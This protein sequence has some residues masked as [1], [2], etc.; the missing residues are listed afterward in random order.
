MFMPK[1]Y[2]SAYEAAKHYGCSSQVI[3]D[4]IRKG[5]LCWDKIVMQR[6]GAK[7]IKKSDL[8][9]FMEKQNPLMVETRR[10]NAYTNVGILP[11][12][13]TLNQFSSKYNI[14]RYQ[15]NKLI[16]ANVIQCEVSPKGWRL[17][18]EQKTCETLKV[19]EYANGVIKNQGDDV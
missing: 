16:D 5:K 3:H 9:T 2:L 17:L 7:R 6:F 14:N 18:P 11:E 12:H 8:E 19:G 1:E 4:Y 10:A 13:L 15:L